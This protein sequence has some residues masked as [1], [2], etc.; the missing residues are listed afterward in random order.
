ML[1]NDY[2]EQGLLSITS[3]LGATSAN[4]IYAFRGDLVLKEGE[5]H[6]GKETDRKP[7]EIVLHEAAILADDSRL[8]FVNGLFYDIQDIAVFAKKYQRTLTQ[9]TLILCYV[10]NIDTSLQIDLNGIIYLCEPYRDGMIW[11]ETL[12]LLYLEKA[13]LKGQSAEDKV[14][15]L[16]EA[17][18]QHVSKGPIIGF[19]DALTK[20][21]V[22]KKDLAAGPV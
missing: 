11:N 3:V 2:E 4:G 7:P 18:K 13:D 14:I 9:E 16:Y 1:L 6:K 21:I 15:T 19:D 8:L 22:V 10:E 5:L 17:A 12:D 20:T